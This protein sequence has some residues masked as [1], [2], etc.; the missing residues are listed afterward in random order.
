MKSPQELLPQALQCGQREPH[1]VRGEDSL[2]GRRSQAVIPPKAGRKGLVLTGKPIQ[3]RTARPIRQ[4][5]FPF[6][7]K[8]QTHREQVGGTKW[9]KVTAARRSRVWSG[10]GRSLELCATGAFTCN[11][12]CS[13]LSKLDGRR[14]CQNKHPGRVTVSLFC[15]L[16]HLSWVLALRFLSDVCAGITKK[17]C[18]RKHD[19]IQ[20]SNRPNR[21]AQIDF[22]DRS[23]INLEKGGVARN[24]HWISNSAVNSYVSAQS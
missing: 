9:R 22:P 6:A 12:R 19:V 2:L 21:C 5:G 14:T 23:V 15:F 11:Q 7:S 4:S 16:S 3:S 17:R 10:R 24:E 1:T 13:S 8:K 20:T 18:L